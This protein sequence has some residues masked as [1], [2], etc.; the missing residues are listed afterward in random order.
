MG[1]RAIGHRLYGLDG[2]RAIAI[3]VLVLGHC[4]QADFWYGT[5]T[6]LTF[7]LPKGCLSILFVL[8]GFLAG[9]FAEKNVSDIKSYYLKRAKRILPIYY[10]YIVLVIIIYI[11]LGKSEEILNAKL[12]YYIIPAGI[13]P[14]CKSEGILPLVHLWFLTPVII[15]YLIHPWIE[16][17]SQG[18]AKKRSPASIALIICGAIMLIK[19][20][21]R[22]VSGKEAIIY[23]I[24][25]ASQFDCIFGGVYLGHKFKDGN[26][27]FAKV[28]E[29]NITQVI[30]WLLFIGS[31]YYSKY[32][33]S[34]IQNEFFG[35]IAAG[36]ILGS[37]SD[38]PLIRFRDKIWKF[39]SKISYNLYVVHILIIILVALLFSAMYEGQSIPIIMSICA[40]IIMVGLSI[41]AAWGTE[42]VLQLRRRRR[43]RNLPI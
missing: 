23:R 21:T 4:C 26:I 36:L 41:L 30:F 11:L 5:S 8:S 9:L 20:S 14:F 37:I 17:W 12:F 43:R 3:L 6:I 33:P 25:G 19:W 18:G 24:L 22:I 28:F 1:D 32:I 34:P 16:N 39:L 27:H 29:H 7:P 13:I 40:Q 38:K 15:F 10:S 35:I 42:K 31:A 2:L